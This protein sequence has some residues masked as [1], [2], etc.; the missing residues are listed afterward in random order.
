MCKRYLSVTIYI[1]FIL[2]TCFNRR[3]ETTQKSDSTQ[4]SVMP[5]RHRVDTY[6]YRVLTS[7]PT[8]C[9][10]L[11]L[12]AHRTCRAHAVDHFLP[13]C[14]KKKWV[15]ENVSFCSVYDGQFHLCMYLLCGRVDPLC[16]FILC[17]CAYKWEALTPWTSTILNIFRGVNISYYKAHW[18][19]TWQQHCNDY[20]KI[21]AKPSVYSV[22]PMTGY[23]NEP[24]KLIHN[25]SNYNLIIF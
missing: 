13:G 14:P 7:V 1:L 12:T 4:K 19:G 24:I 3:M 16:V 20:T 21:M 9:A 5:P 10:R 15:H 23:L 6:I 22:I 18:L 25:D 17:Q 11:T 2:S 8:F